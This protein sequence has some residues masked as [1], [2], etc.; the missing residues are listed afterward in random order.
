[1]EIYRGMLFLQAIDI[2]MRI[3]TALGSKI[4]LIFDTTLLKVSLSL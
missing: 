4:R 3:K 1:M 2:T